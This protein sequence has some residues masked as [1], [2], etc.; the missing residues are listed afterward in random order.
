MCISM[1]SSFTNRRVN[2]CMT[3]SL[4]IVVEDNIWNAIEEAPEYKGLA[5]LLWQCYHRHGNTS[6]WNHMEPIIG[7][8]FYNK[9]CVWV[10]VRGGVLLV[11]DI[12]INRCGDISRNLNKGLQKTYNSKWA[13]FTVM[14]DMNLQVTV[15]NATSVHS[16]C[17][18]LYNIEEYRIYIPPYC[19]FVLIEPK[20]CQTLLSPMIY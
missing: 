15:Y 1:I 2:Q 4:N 17:E 5:S 9:F 19:V 16:S 18:A 20:S 12:T 11:S 10:I 7:T 8:K 13:N 14:Y 3:N 6:I